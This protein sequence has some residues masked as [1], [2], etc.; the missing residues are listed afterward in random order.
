[1]PKKI[2]GKVVDISSLHMKKIQHLQQRGGIYIGNNRSY[3]KKKTIGD[4]FH[5]L[6]NFDLYGHN[7]ALHNYKLYVRN[8]PKLWKALDF[9]E[10][11]T[12]LCHCSPPM[13]HGDMLLELLWEKK[14]GIPPD[15]LHDRRNAAESSCQETIPANNVRSYELPASNTQKPLTLSDICSGMCPI[16]PKSVVEGRAVSSP[17]GCG[18]LLNSYTNPNYH[19]P[20]SDHLPYGTGQKR[21]CDDFKTVSKFTFEVGTK[22]ALYWPPSVNDPCVLVAGHSQLRTFATGRVSCPDDWAVLSVPGGLFGHVEAAIHHVASK[23]YPGRDDLKA[24]VLMCGTN[25]LVTVDSHS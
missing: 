5:N 24:I 17:V 19:L 12:L 16:V 25:D 23:G 14:H 3:Y 7:H 10:G 6:Y 20:P 1:M 2:E 18:L 21:L 22:T 8:N 15:V 9:L 4:L 13:C 11:K